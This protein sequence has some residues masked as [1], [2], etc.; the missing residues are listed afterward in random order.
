MRCDREAHYIGREL[1]PD[2]SVGRLSLSRPV[3]THPQPLSPHKKSSRHDSPGMVFLLLLLISFR[4][5]AS[6]ASSPLSTAET[7]DGPAELPREYVKRS[8]KDTPANGKIWLVHSGEP[9]EPVLK[10]ASCGDIVQLQSGGTF[11]G[12]E[13]PSK[14]CD[15]AHWIVIR[16]SAPD[17]SLPPEGTRLTPCFAGVASLAGR[18]PW[19]CA[20]TGNVL[21]KIEFKGKGGSGPITFA[22]GAN[23]YRLLGLEVTRALS[24][25]CVHNLV[26]FD[27]PADHV[28]F[29]R[30]WMH[31][32]AQDETVRGI[33]LGPSRYVAVVDSFFSDFHCV[34]KSGACVDTQ[35][36]AGGLGDNP[37]GPYKIENN[38]LEAAGEN[39]LFGGGAATMTPQDIEIRH[40]HLFRPNEWKIGDP[41]FVGGHDGNPFIV[42][43]CFE[44]KNAQRVLVEGNVM[45]NSWG[46]FS[47]T[48]FAILLTPK[49]Q[50]NRCPLCRV[51]DIIIRFNKIAHMGSGMQIGNGLSDSGG[52][53][54]DG[55]RYSIHDVTFEDIRGAA[56][57]GY[58]AFAQISAA[59]PPL[60]DVKLDHLTGFAPHSLFILGVRT[61]IPKIANFVFTNNI[62]STGNP[63]VVTTG[64]GAANCAF[65][66]QR[67]GMTA[68]LENCFSNATVTHNALVGDSAGWPKENMTFKDLQAVGFAAVEKDEVADFHL[69]PHS[70]CKRA[71]S[72]GRD[73]GA[74]VAALDSATADVE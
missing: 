18:P 62:V 57:G 5:L 70:R 32:T 22:A 9:I 26:Q 43:N 11:S 29:D 58:G 42:K 47:Q 4:A 61:S 33:M 50:G 19:H 12:L 23:H 40:N 67:Q 38:F 17:S 72:D 46:G 74:D 53:S 15:D 68:L 8:L 10:G 21:A 51:T 14:N 44:L 30:L 54:T 45:E 20:S 60:H 65:Q 3:V 13:L 25:A 35:A 55:G 37:M 34:A 6:G 63:V 56:S 52:A 27:G 71:G 66:P 49:N 41:H 1:T 16:T 28:V 2:L 69:L 48:G 59:G 7:H 24:T 64:G 36:I 39:V 31:G 73:L